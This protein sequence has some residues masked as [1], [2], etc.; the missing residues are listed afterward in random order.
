MIITDKLNNRFRGIRALYGQQKF[1]LFANSHIV[2]VGAGGVGS[3]AIEALVRSGIGKITI[4]DNDEI[5]ET[6]INRQL[7]TLLSTI[8]KSKCEELKNRMLQINDEAEIIT[9]QDFL[10]CTNVDRLIDKNVSF[11]IDAIDSLDSKAALIHFAKIHNIPIIVSGGAGGKIIPQN[12]QITDLSMVT[13]DKLLSRLRI[14]LRKNY[15]FPKNPQK[16]KVNAVY[17]VEQ[18]ILSS[19]YK[20]IKDVPLF[21]ASMSVTATMGLNL[22]GYVLNNL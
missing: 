19:N 11:I 2:V 10:S 4:I 1:E 16:M 7:H 15:N 3:W 6:N 21:G 17:S 12:I 9:I 18:S 14:I 5:A 8:G 20:D 13:H 22:A